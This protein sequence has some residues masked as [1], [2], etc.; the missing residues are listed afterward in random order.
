MEF[1]N[2]LKPVYKSNDKFSEIKPFVDEYLGSQAK[3]DFLNHIKM[4]YESDETPE[5]GFN[6]ENE[7]DLYRYA[8]TFMYSNPEDFL[9]AREA[10]APYFEDWL[11]K[12]A[13]GAEL[14]KKYKGIS[15]QVSRRYI[16]PYV[17][18]LLGYK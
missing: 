13:Q 17:K 6:L 4:S 7:E 11:S 2:K 9:E 16:D 10:Y 18:K 12:N 15:N 14:L 3:Q 8:D 5:E 1:N